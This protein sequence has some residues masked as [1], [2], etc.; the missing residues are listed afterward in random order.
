MNIDQKSMRLGAGQFVAETHT[1]DLIVLHH[2][3]GGTARSTFNYWQDD[4]RR[5]A[6]AFII[7]RDGTIYE[8]F[9][10]AYWAYHVAVPGAGSPLEKR[11]I[12]IELASEGGLTASGGS[13]YSF[14]V[15][16]PKTRHDTARFVLPTPWRG[17]K[18]FDEYEPAQ[19]TSVCWLVNDL[20]G[21]FANIPKRI[22]APSQDGFP[23]MLPPTWRGVCGHSGMRQD[24]T[25]PH[26]G[27]PWATLAAAAGLSV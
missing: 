10:P 26:P 17:F 19:I 13:Y 24:K 11:S 15:V 27:F 21:R 18:A 22:P 25:D 16:S 2:T 1:K 14:G 20:M 3:V 7:D 9:D 23:A 6:T 8:T 12:G 5:V 4:P